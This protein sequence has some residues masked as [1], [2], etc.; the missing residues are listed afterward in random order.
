VMFADRGPSMTLVRDLAACGF[1]GV[2]L[3]TADKAQGGLRSHL[4]PQEI[5]DFLAEAHRCSLLAGLAGSLR[6]SDTQTLLP[7]RPD[8]LGFRGALCAGEARAEGL[9]IQRVTAM[10]RLIRQDDAVP[11]A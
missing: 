11:V 7:L 1:A 9:D 5:V 3:D 8:V 10:R 6:G 4:R 2:M